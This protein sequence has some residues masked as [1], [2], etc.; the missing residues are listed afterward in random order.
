MA[1]SDPEGILASPL[2]IIDRQDEAQDLESITSLISQHG[3][4]RV[5]VGLPLSMDGSRGSQAEKVMAFTEKL[6]GAASV[7]VEYRDERLTTVAAGRLLH[8]AHNGKKRKRARDDA[9]A[10]AIILKGYLDEE[11]GPDS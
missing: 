9:A 10:A 3:V 7:P 6:R 1:L 11:T 8:Q 5:I 2:T 4:G